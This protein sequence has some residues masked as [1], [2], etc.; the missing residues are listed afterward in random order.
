M[1]H[2]VY[3][4]TYVEPFWHSCDETNLTMVCDLF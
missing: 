2:Y 3:Q 1:L 4:F